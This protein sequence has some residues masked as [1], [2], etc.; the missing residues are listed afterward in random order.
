LLLTLISI[1]SLNLNAEIFKK[2]HGNIIYFTLTF[3]GATLAVL[4]KFCLLCIIC[5]FIWRVYISETA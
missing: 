3:T 2:Y 5:Y 1:C 4:V